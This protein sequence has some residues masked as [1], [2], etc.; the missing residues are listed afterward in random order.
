MSGDPRWEPFCMVV[1]EP[2]AEQRHRAVR[3]VAAHAEN[4]EDLAELLDMLG[5]LAMDGHEPPVQTEERA[6]PAG[7]GPP[8]EWLARLAA[9]RREL[10]D[11][12]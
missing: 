1:K 8:P 7:S 2:T 4:A 11:R 3:A 12:H 5:L 9:L 10:T 6:E